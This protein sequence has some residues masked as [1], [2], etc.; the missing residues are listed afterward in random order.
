LKLM[1]FEKCK[2]KGRGRGFWVFAC[3][4]WVGL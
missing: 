1:F 2:N 4:L 3:N